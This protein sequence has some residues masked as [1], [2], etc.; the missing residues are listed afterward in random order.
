MYNRKLIT[1]RCSN[2]S[3]DFSET[4]KQTSSLVLSERLYKHK[5]LSKF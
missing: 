4:A 5:N 2:G 1:E 3:P